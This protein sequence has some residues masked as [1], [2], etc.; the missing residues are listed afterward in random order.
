VSPQLQSVKMA[1]EQIPNF[2]LVIVR[3]K[4]TP[5]PSDPTQS[6][7]GLLNGSFYKVGIQSI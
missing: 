3:Y 5:K 4:D 6:N 2:T 7:S 1:V